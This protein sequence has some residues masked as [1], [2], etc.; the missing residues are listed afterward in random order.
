MKNLLI[1]RFIDTGAWE[2]DW[3]M[4]QFRQNRTDLAEQHRHVGFAPVAAGTNGNGDGH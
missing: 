1:L 4:E 3:A 2:W